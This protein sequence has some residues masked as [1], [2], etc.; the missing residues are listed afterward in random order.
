LDKRLV[1]KKGIDKR[2][3]SF[4]SKDNSGQINRLDWLNER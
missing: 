4:I 1:S 2:G 3:Y